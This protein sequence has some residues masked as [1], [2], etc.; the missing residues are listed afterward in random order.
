MFLSKFYALSLG[1][2]VSWMTFLL[3]TEAQTID[4]VG[5]QRGLQSRDLCPGVYRLGLGTVHIVHHRS[6]K[7]D[8][9][10]IGASLI[11]NGTGVTSYNITKFYGKR[12]NG[13]FRADILFD[14]IT[15]ANDAVA[16]MAYVIYNIG[17]GSHSAVMQK[18]G[19]A[20]FALA[21]KGAKAAATAPKDTAGHIVG[22]AVADLVKGFLIQL[23]H[24]VGGIFDF[25]GIVDMIKGPKGC[26]DQTGFGAHGFSGSD[27][28]SKPI[29]N[30]TGTDYNQ[31]DPYNTLNVPGIICSEEVS[32]YNVG[33]FAGTKETLGNLTVVASMNGGPSTIVGAGPG[34]LGWMLVVGGFVFVL[35]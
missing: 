25:V 26:D 1:A 32:Q 10:Y 29:A 23:D 21:K 22:N 15:V 9:V 33:W 28:C 30:L 8:S 3:G 35:W 20:S 5:I 18:M 34:W 17:H 27:L 16:V 24:F 19:N 13:R 4:G 6:E 14:N 11:V 12:G 31:G 2:I 7:K